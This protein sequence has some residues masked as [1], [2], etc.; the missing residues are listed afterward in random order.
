[1]AIKEQQ[2]KYILSG[3]CEITVNTPPENLKAMREASFNI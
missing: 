1:L 2:R 3:G